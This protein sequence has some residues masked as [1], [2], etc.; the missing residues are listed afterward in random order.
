[1]GSRGP[2]LRRPW[3]GSGFHDSRGKPRIE[4]HVDVDDPPHGDGP[5]GR[6]PGRARLRS[7]G[8]GP[9]IPVSK[10]RITGYR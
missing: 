5:V 10:V 3:K 1:M 6:R 9:W 2:R 7:R 4:H 8:Q